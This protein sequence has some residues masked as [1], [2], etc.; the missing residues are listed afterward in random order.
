MFGQKCFWNEPSAL[1]IYVPLVSDELGYTQ[2][3]KLSTEEALL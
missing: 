1:V 2:P 3:E